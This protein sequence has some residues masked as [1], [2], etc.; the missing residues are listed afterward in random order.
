MQDVGEKIGELHGV[1]QKIGQHLSLYFI[2]SQHDFRQLYSSG[3]KEH[4]PVEPYLSAQGLV[5]TSIVA[6]AQASIGQVYKVESAAARLAVK[7]KYPDIENRM[8][9]D[10]KLLSWLLLFTKLL[11]IRHTSVE[12]TVKNIECSVM[13]ECNY[14]AEAAVQQQ[15]RRFFQDVPNIQIPSI[16]QEYSSE[17]IIVSDWVEGQFLHCYLEV[18]DDGQKLQTFSL[19][20]EFEMACL[21]IHGLVHTDPHPGNFLIQEEEGN[22]KLNVL[23]FGNVTS[24]TNTEV[25]AM[26]RILLANYGVDGL[27]QD[28]LSLGFNKETLAYYD[29]ILGDIVTI[30]LEPFYFPVDYNFADW[31]MHYKMNTLMASR[32]W[33][34]PFEIPAKIAGIIRMFHGLYYYARKYQICFNWHENL[35]GILSQSSRECNR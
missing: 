1:P 25:A 32:E 29:D 21:V 17:N 9:L 28:L 13:Q 23:D 8:R 15:M 33:N 5:C 7:V 10:F 16:Y 18:A 14:I 30:L 27:K 20:F 22:I 24:I 6:V 19:L 4:I 2:E 12:A 3:R 11:P 26:C 31:R 35:R 34:E